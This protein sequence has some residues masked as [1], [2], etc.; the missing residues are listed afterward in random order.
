M[1]RHAGDDSTLWMHT[2]DEG[3]MDN[4][5]YLKSKTDRSIEIF[6]FSP[7]TSCLHQLSDE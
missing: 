2:G 3:I 7:L 6:S 1:R 4:E 5:G